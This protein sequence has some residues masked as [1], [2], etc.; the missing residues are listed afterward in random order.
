TLGGEN[1]PLTFRNGGFIYKFNDSVGPVLTAAIRKA[2]EQAKTDITAQKLKIDW[3][4]V[5][6]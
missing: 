5:K 6:Y 1:I 3:Q 2:A 4:A